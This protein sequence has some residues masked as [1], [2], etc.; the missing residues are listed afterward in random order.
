MRALC[1]SE[2]PF[3]PTLRLSWYRAQQYL[4]AGIVVVESLQL[5][6]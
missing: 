3:E 4:K 6:S 5:V 2:C 1:G